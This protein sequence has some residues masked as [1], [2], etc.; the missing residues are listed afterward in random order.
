MK[1]LFLHDVLTTLRESRLYF[2]IWNGEHFI[3]DRQRI[4]KTSS[5]DALAELLMNNNYL[6]I[7][8]FSD[9]KQVMPI[10][11]ISVHFKPIFKYTCYDAWGHEWA[12]NWSSEFSIMACNSI[13]ARHH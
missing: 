8:I 3:V 6:H 7:R 5:V 10:S 9:T 13:T 1:T 11:T 2:Q 4:K 12:G